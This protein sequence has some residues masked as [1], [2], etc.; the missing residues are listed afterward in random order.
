[1]SVDPLVWNESDPTNGDFVAEGDDNFR[2]VKTA[3]RYGMEKEHAWPS[4][5]TGTAQRGYHTL[6]T[7]SG[8]TA[9]PALTY[10][11]ITTQLAAIWCS[12]GSKAVMV[13]D[14]AGSNYTLLTSG[15]GVT[16]ISGVYSATGTLG[17]MVIGSS[18][19]QLAIL[20][21]GSS[22]QI[23]TASTGGTGVIWSSAATQVQFFHYTTLTA[24]TQLG[25][26]LKVCEGSSSFTGAGNATITNLP[27]ANATS[28]GITV[29]QGTGIY[30][31]SPG[32]AIVDGTSATIFNNHGDAQAFRWLAIGV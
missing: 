8:Q 29:C 14:S 27:F 7:L 24:S 3:V 10:G 1:M 13:T 26:I 22:G 4:S 12:S 30:N 21:P 2:A 16:I 11:S 23:L 17:E 20:S 25:T 19:G 5:Q 31:E 28:Y 9:A 18:G 15:K 6:I 32:V